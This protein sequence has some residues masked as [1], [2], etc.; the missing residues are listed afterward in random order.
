[1]LKYIIFFISL[2]SLSFLT[3]FPISEY[4]GAFHI[5]GMCHYS[6][7]GDEY[8]RPCDP[9]YYCL[10]DPNANHQIGKC[11]KY[12]SIVGMIGGS[13][14]SNFE[15]D[16]NLVCYLTNKNCTVNDNE[17]AYKIYDKASDDK[18]YYC[19]KRL[20]AKKDSNKEAICLKDN[21]LEKKCLI[22]VN[23]NKIEAYPGYFQVCGEIKIQSNDVTEIVT[24]FIGSVNDSEYVEDERACASGFALYFYEGK[25]LD[26]GND[27]SKKM[28][29][30]C[31][32]VI[33]VQKEDT[34]C[35]I[36]YNTT[37]GE[38][39]YNLGQLDQ[40][41][42]NVNNIISN[43]EILLTKIELFKEYIGNL[44]SIRSQCEDPEDK[45]KYYNESFTCGN[46]T[47]RRLWY[48]YNH[49]D[50]YLLYEKEPEVLTYLIKN[51]YPS[52]NENEIIK[53]KTNNSSAHLVIKYFIMLLLFLIF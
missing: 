36:K 11:Q 13:C 39:I 34:N 52:Y 43:C 41:S 33:E 20:F 46:D 24:T 31:V 17:E 45:D 44:S 6:D 48:F 47:L 12:S 4:S 1:M 38:G 22:T 14:S 15:C 5:E 26:N 8:V 51:I 32:S 9:G 3:Y 50:E 23:S 18:L 37:D 2:F 35:I 16:N 25:T 42:Y 7:N 40:N 28:F 19:P 49:P 53:Q 30:R 21:T 29:K 27:P 10:Y